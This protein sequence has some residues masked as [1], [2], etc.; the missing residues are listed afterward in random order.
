[1][2]AAVF[3]GSVVL[4]AASAFGLALWMAERKGRANAELDASKKGQAKLA[5]AVEA[6]DRARADSAR[7]GLYEDDGHRR[8]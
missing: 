3:F 4:F 2:L 1:M 7:G 5:K 8:D 6:D